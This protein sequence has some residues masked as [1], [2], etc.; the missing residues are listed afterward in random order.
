MTDHRPR[1]VNRLAPTFV[2]KVKP[3]TKVKDY[4]DGNGLIL[5][6]HPN[7]RKQWIWRGT[8]RGEGR[9]RMF[10]LGSPDYI[11]VAEARETARN[12]KKLARCELSGR[13][14]FGPVERS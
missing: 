1:V 2:S 3:T 5:R 6:V 4:R 10:G 13:C 9:E 11:S 14:P 7:G 8:I 12:F